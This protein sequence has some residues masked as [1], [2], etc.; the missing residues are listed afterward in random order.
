[1][2]LPK[3]DVVLFLQ[4]SPGEAASR[5]RYGEERYE[6]AAFQSA[7]LDRFRQLMDDPSIN[8][9]VTIP[10]TVLAAQSSSSLI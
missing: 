7:V 10:K 6:D 2:G 9:K 5:G 4:L 1:M 8:W 3:P